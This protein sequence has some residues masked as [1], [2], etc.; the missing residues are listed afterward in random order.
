M[1][2]PNCGAA[3]PAEATTCATCGAT[4]PPASSTPPPPP[5]PQPAPGAV[6]LPSD[7]RT[8][9][10]AA[11]I[12]APILAVVTGGILF[13]LGPLIVWLIKRDDHPF[14]A[15]HGREALNF[16]LTFLI[17]GVALVIV[18]IPVGIA[19]IG[20]GLIPLAILAFI[21]GIGWLVLSIVAG[22]KASN[23]ESYRYP[24]TMRLVN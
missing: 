1:T 8:W 2:C 12:S 20:L 17:A 3:A 5:G 19:T 6:P 10:M 13:F 11:H 4:L 23:G 24:F 9:A 14:I 7:V 18:A 16:N 15:Y 21:I 22:V